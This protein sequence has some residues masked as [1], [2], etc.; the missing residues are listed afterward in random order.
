MNF[1]IFIMCFKLI[2]ALIITL[3]LIYVMSKAL[4]KGTQK[5]NGYRHMQILER[6]QVTKECTLLIVKI[7]SRGCVLAVSSGSIERLYE[8]S[9]EEIKNIEEDKEKLKQDDIALKFF[10]E[11]SQRNKQIITKFKKKDKK[12]EY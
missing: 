12:N 6:M 7:E 9:E 11:F 4:G 5:F 1:E 2:V 3:A 8:L 10:N